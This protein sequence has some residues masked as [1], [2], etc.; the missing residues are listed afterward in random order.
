MSIKSAARAG[1]K[2][3]LRR[4]TTLAAPIRVDVRYGAPPER[5]FNA[6]LDRDVAR[7]WLFATATQPLA[8][9]DIDARCGGSFR[10]VERGEFGDVEH[11]G[12]YVEIVAHRRLVFTLA[13]ADRLD[14]LTRVS[15]DVE[16][17]GKDCA[18]FL[19][20][21]RVP[22]D[23]VYR[24]E[25]RWIGMLY[26]LGVTLGALTRGPV[27]ARRSISPDIVLPRLLPARASARGRPQSSTY[28]RSH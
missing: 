25:T 17:R 20:H 1:N 3:R 9:I 18:L 7:Q 11:H 14:A 15:V 19:A 2:P 24:T 13:L 12:E 27:S 26:G 8:R 28:P 6:W 21:E 5:V 23:M 22:F 16:T 10:L 4:A